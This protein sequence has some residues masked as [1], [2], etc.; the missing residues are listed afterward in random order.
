MIF[1][2]EEKVQ[3]LYTVPLSKAYEYTRTKRARRA[4]DVLRTFLARH[5]KVHPGFVRIS[6]QLN[7]YIW[8]RSMEK[9]P[10]KVKISVVKENGMAR[11]S[12]PDETPKKS[13]IPVKKEP[14]AKT[15]E[16]K[17]EAKEA[18]KATEKKPEVKGE[19]EKKPAAKKEHKPGETKK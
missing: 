14:K 12:L 10:R 3:R 7:E 15:T 9:P 19:A 13:R 4:V 5:M 1:M 17:T 2:A 18:T 6:E 16:T 11:A 8:S